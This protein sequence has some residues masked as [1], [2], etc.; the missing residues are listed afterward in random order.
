MCLPVP[1]ASGQA[2]KPPLPH[3]GEVAQRLFWERKPLTLPG[4]PAKRPKD[5]VSEC[6]LTR[7]P[8]GSPPASA[9]PAFTG[10]EPPPVSGS[11]RGSC[12]A[13]PS[14]NAGR[15]Q[16]FQGDIPWSEGGGELR[17]ASLV[18]CLASHHTKFPGRTTSRGLCGRT[19]PRCHAGC[20]GSRASPSG[21][22]GVCCLR[23]PVG[24]GQ[25]EN[26]PPEGRAA[27]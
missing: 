22:T 1:G 20:R 2:G 14:R 25:S 3:L 12:A 9:L 10:R 11:C 8:G 5:E 19:R 4:L 24:A 17:V 21:E 27:L 26:A 6:E 16:M 7:A 23:D 18:L 15:A 13:A